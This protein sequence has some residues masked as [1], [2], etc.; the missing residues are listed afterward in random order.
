MSMMFS[1]DR[2]LPDDITGMSFPA[3]RLRRGIDEDEVQAFLDRV[4]AE[5]SRLLEER[6]SLRKQVAEQE[7][8][9]HG[10]QDAV[11]VNHS[12]ASDD[13]VRILSQAQRVADEAVAESQ[14]Y[15]A[16][17]QQQARQR[18]EQIVEEARSR[19]GFLMEELRTRA[20]HETAV[21]LGDRAVPTG[22]GAADALVRVFGDVFRAN[23]RAQ[24][25]AWAEVLDDWERR[26]QLSFAPVI[27]EAAPLA[28]PA[29]RVD[30]SQP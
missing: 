2:L 14:R 3:T 26:E 21:E 1:D 19:S 9:L 6:L 30:T 20:H 10:Q 4:A 7:A 17:L 22:P 18:Y 13:A 23:V 27:A 28:E 5:V 16:W 25:A 29:P 8:A 15:A 24:L 12:R 11:E